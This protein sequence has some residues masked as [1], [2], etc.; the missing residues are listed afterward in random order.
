MSI[1]ISGNGSFTGANSD[2]SFDQSVGIAGTLTY[3]D[4][5]SIDSVGIITARS[6]INVTGGSVGIGTDNPVQALDVVGII[7]SNGRYILATQDDVLNIG[8]ITAS[9]SLGISTVRIFTSDVERIRIDSSGNVGIGTDIPG[10]KLHVRKDGTYALKVGGE[11]GAAF[12]LELGQPEASASPGINYTGTNASLRFL[13][14]GSDVARFDSSGRF[15][16]GASSSIDTAAYIQSYRASGTNTITIQSGSTANNETS[17]VI[18]QTLSP[19]NRFSQFAVGKHSNITNPVGYLELNQEDG[20]QSFFWF[21]NSAIARTSPTF[22]HT[23][24]TNGTVIGTQ[25][26]DER[27]KNVGAN[28]AY[29]LAE[30]KRLQPKQYTLKTEPDTNK[31]GFIAQ[32]VESIIPEA[33]FNTGV[34]LTDHQNGDRTQL[35]MEYVQLIPVLVNAIKELSSKVETLEVEVQAL[36]GS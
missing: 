8:G 10:R 12:Y 34:E 19:A 2:Y 25:T 29:G 3:E 13:N 24:T 21:D 28:V 5:T 17:R 32:E 6:G 1:S 35:G 26:S 27:L 18:V 16:V 14:N 36:K 4:V 30:V 20:N 31:L 23:G 33:V 7:A 9:A 15:L 22:S 11:S